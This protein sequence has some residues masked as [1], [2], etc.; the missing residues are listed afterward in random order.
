MFLF[1]LTS[2]SRSLP[3]FARIAACA[4]EATNTAQRSPA[5]DVAESDDSYSISVDLPGVNKQD[6]KIAIEGR[7]VSVSAQAASAA[8]PNDGERVIYRERLAASFARS[9]TLPEEIDQDAS[10]AKL[11]NGVLSLTLSKKRSAA[12]KHLTV[13]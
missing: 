7:H 8:A 10:L 11:D 2:P 3:H 5:L 4:A 13:N 6:V 12:G 9:F 1:P